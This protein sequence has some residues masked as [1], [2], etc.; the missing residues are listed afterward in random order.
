MLQLT[1]SSAFLVVTGLLG[2]SF[3]H[4]LKVNPGIRLD[5]RMLVMVKLTD[6]DLRTVED[7]Q[8]FFSHIR[9][10]LL[11]HTRRTSGCDLLLCAAG[12][13]QHQR[14]PY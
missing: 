4:L 3:Y 8:Q 10:Q 12:R 1:F 9:D 11:L 14:L 2:I 6:P 5:Q 13:A 7:L